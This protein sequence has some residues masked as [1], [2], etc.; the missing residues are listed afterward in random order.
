MLWN[1]ST[2]EGYGIKASDGEI[3]RVTDL[4]FDDESWMVRWL[5][6]ET[7][8]WLFGRKILLPTFNIGYLDGADR[9]CQV[10]LTRQQIKDS[11]DIDMAQP[12]SRQMEANIFD[13][14]GWSPYWGNGYY[15]GGYANL[16]AIAAPPSVDPIWRVRHDVNYRAGDPHLRSAEEVT[17]YHIHAKDGEIGHVADFLVEDG[18]WSIHYLVV[19]TKNWW[20]GK[21]VLL[22]PR[23]A[24]HIDWATNL[25]NLAITRQRV[26]DSPAYDPALT[27]DRIYE[28][29]FHDYY[30]DDLGTD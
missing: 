2:I 10:R 20:P 16:G 13:Y 11:P 9:V 17:G 12:V 21:K 22:S 5:V 6:V 27:V 28:K 1:A 23:W 4:L 30:G 26:Q 24:H 7:G 25:I 29:H 19:D 8:P 3:G 15:T 18:D 14:Y